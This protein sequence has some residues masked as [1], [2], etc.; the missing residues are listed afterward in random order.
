MGLDEKLIKHTFIIFLLLSLIFPLEWLTT[1]P[2]QKVVIAPLGEEPLKLLYPFLV[3]YAIIWAKRNKNPYIDY[4]ETFSRTFV[5]P[6]V[7][8]G[9]LFGA[10]EYLGGAP[11]SNILLHFSFT[12]IGAV[13]IVL[14]FDKVRYPYKK[15]G[16]L[17]ISVSIFL[18]S[19]SNQYANVSSVTEKNS[20]LVC[21]AK[22]LIKNT[23]LI[24]QWDYARVIY[25]ITLALFLIY[26]WMYTMPEIKRKLGGSKSN[27]N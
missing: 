10:Y 12:T 11:G 4:K 9:I 21:T 27:E 6:S 17:L 18:H 20:Y 13:L 16:F 25:W 7:I 26:F 23:P 22:F 1:G 15:V 5:Y 24:S 2:F 14:W 3:Y 19:I 8:A